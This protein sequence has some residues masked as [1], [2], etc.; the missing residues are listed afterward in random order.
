MIS[1]K[2]EPPTIKKANDEEIGLSCDFAFAL[3]DSTTLVL[4]LKLNTFEVLMIAENLVIIAD[5]PIAA[6]IQAIGAS[7]SINRTITPAKYHARVP[8]KIM[9]IAPSEMLLNMKNKPTGANGTKT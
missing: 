8:Y 6:N 3:F 7:V 9:K 2:A 1:K 5:N 4:L